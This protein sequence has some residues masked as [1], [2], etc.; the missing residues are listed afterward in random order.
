M[1][2]YYMHNLY[3]KKYFCSLTPIPLE[4]DLHPLGGE[5]N[6]KLQKCNIFTW[7]CYYKFIVFKFSI[8]AHSS[9]VPW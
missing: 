1:H 9:R 3:L 7:Y 2:I 5:G 6:A 4:R 8:Y